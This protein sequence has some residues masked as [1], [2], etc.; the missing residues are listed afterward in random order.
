[1]ETPELYFVRKR[2]E[3]NGA[4]DLSGEDLLSPANS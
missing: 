3:L 1:M 2:K 4:N